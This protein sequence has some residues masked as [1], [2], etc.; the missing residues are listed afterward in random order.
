MS[1]I[2]HIYSLC[3]NNKKIRWTLK[4]AEEKREA[5]R[6][7]KRVRA[8]G[9]S[10]L[11]N[12]ETHFSPGEKPFSRLSCCA[13]CLPRQLIYNF[14]LRLFMARRLVAAPR[15]SGI[16]VFI[17]DR[18]NETSRKFLRKEFSSPLSIISLRPLFILK[19]R[20]EL[21][22]SRFYEKYTFNI[23]IFSI[24]TR[25]ETPEKIIKEILFFVKK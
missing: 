7:G 25:S 8:P 24:V 13:A 20:I 19:S 23:F 10:A 14:Y 1:L 5:K 3:Q 11:E 15:R 18:T 16:A 17:S 6:W 9:R 21:S 12:A 22:F 4:G 2:I